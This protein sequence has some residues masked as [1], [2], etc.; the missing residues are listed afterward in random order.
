MKPIALKNASH[1]LNHSHVLIKGRITAG[2]M[3]A[4]TDS[5]VSVDMA[6]NGTPVVITRAGRQS[7]LKVQ[8]MVTQGTVA[9]MLDEGETY[10][11]KLPGEA[12]DLLPEDIDYICAQIDAK[13]KPLNAEEQQRFLNSASAP[14]EGS[15]STMR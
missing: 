11:V 1:W 15:L 5:M 3:A 8:R 6:S 2:D 9:V 13:G 7:I 4:I 14:A 12:E 10:E